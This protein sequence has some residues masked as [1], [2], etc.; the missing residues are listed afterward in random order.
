[1]CVF[2]FLLSPCAAMNTDLSTLTYEE[3]RLHVIAMEGMLYNARKEMAFRE[4][5]RYRV[6][7]L[8][9]ARDEPKSLE[10]KMHHAEA[11]LRNYAGFS[12]DTMKLGLTS[13]DRAFEFKRVN[14][15]L[16]ASWNTVING[17]CRMRVRYF[18]KPET[19]M[20]L[21]PGMVKPVNMRLTHPR[22]WFCC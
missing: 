7:C 1:L 6:V 20:I 3:A 16:H 10:W 8:E 4:M 22:E 2:V 18:I 19:F 12:S 13:A 14:D 21:G 11:M 9:L 5:D 15:E 17:S